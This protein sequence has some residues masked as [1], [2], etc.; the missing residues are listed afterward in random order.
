MKNWVGK[1]KDLMYENPNIRVVPLVDSE[2]V[3]DDC[4]NS[5]FAEVNDVYVDEIMW[6]GNENIPFDISLNDEINYMKSNPN[7]IIDALFDTYGH[8]IENEYESMINQMPWEKVI[9]LKIGV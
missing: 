7:Q 3:M 1:L 2:V 9:I 6:G 4:Y 5:W 8:H